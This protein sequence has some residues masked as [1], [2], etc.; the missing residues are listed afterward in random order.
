MFLCVATKRL[1]M[2]K[3]SV[4]NT[5]MPTH[6]AGCRAQNH[7]CRLDDVRLRNLSQFRDGPPFDAPEVVGAAFARASVPVQ[8]RMRAD[9][10]S[11]KSNEVVDSDL[12]KCDEDK[13]ALSAARDVLVLVVVVVIATLGPVAAAPV[14]AVSRN[15]ARV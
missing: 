11:L 15:P 14:V 3:V 6:R 4:N 10:D 1:R 5:I 13:A 9:Y 12:F 7:V 8:M 2:R